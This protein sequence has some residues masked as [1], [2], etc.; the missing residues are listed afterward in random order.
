MRVL[1]LAHAIPYPPKA[2]FLLRSYYLLK[3][4]ARAYPVDLIAFVQRPWVTT[5]FPSFEAGLEE[6][7]RALEQVCARVTFLPIDRTERPWG[8]QRTALEALLSGDSYSGNWLVSPTARTR[9]ERQAAATRYDLVHF[10]TIGLAPYRSSM[11]GPARTLM[12][13]NIESHMMLRRADNA[14]NPVAAAYFRHEGRLIER[15]E[16]TSAADFDTHITCSELDND[17]LKQLIPGVAPVAVPNGVDCEFFSPREAPHRPQ[18]LIFVGTMNW[19]PNVDA[20]L[21]FLHEVWPLLKPRIPDLTF[22]VA[23]SNPPAA[24]VELAKTLPGVTVHGYVDDVRPMIDSAALFVCP[25]RDGGGTKLKILD[26]LAMKKCIVAHPIACEGI[27]VTPGKDIVFAS[28]PVEFAREIER[29]LPDEPLRRSIGAAGRTLAERQY[30]FGA[31]GQSFAELL[32][33]AASNH[34]KND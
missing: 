27:A 24:L 2:G 8:K 32:G 6:S 21:F 20:V 10:D 17:R 33:R 23:G 4:L 11:N 3:G 22:D 15:L 9:L 31:I 12:H 30:S 14:S 1:W 5:L 29:L 34:R 25:I 16:R 18:S 26:A 28:T 7:Q 19:Y 13:H